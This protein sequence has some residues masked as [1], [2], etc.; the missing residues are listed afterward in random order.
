MEKGSNLK[1]KLIKKLEQEIEDF[2]SE[3]KEKGV[4]YAIDRAYELTSKQEIIDYIQYD[5]DMSKTDIKALITRENLL[6][7]LYA[8]WLETDGNMREHIGYSIDNALDL[9]RSDYLDSVK[10]NKNYDR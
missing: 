6:D 7:E 1:D 5:I 10:K 4:D 8:E 9:I 2:K 3:L